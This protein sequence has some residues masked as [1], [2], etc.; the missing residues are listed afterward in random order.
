[1]HLNFMARCIRFG[2]APLVDDATQLKLI[3]DVIDHEPDMGD[4]D[5]IASC[6]PSQPH[7]PRRITIKDSYHTNVGLHRSSKA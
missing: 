1:M 7:P 3:N 6:V 2:T 5:S 4:A